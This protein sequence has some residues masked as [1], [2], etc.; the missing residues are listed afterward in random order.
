MV[1]TLEGCMFLAE[2]SL[3]LLLVFLSSLVDSDIF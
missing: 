2:D 1:Y 3:K